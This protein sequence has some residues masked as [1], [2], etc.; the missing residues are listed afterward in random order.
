MKIHKSDTVKITKGKDRGKSGKVINVFPKKM[1][2]VVEGINLYK[3]HIRPKT[4]GEKGQVALVPRPLHVA[5]AMLLCS[6][7]HEGTRVGYRQDEQ[8]KIRY[9]K[10]CGALIN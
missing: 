10:K 8:K 4:Q 2:I 3:K 6:S 1:K 9:C 7:C 5:N